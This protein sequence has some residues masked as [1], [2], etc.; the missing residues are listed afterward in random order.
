MD[1]ATF[2]AQYLFPG[3]IF[4]VMFGLG[5]SLT[6]ASFTNVLQVPRAVLV[7]LAGQMIFLPGLS[8]WG[9]P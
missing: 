5:L 9:S 4:I 8:P 6:P 2:N 1:L 3:V 7:G